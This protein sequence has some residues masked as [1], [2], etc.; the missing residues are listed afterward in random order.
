MARQQLQKVSGAKELI[1]GH[2]WEIFHSSSK[3]DNMFYTKQ[4]FE[5]F[6]PSTLCS[7]APTTTSWRRSDGVFFSEV[8]D[9]KRADSH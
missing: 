5:G 9:C 8:L 1:L 2:I 6:C 3:L 7:D 4:D